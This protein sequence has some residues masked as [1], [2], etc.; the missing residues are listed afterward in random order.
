MISKNNY[1]KTGSQH[2]DIWVCFLLVAA[3]LA[4]YIQ[5]INHEFVNFDDPVYVTENRHVKGGLTLEG[6]IWAITTTYG[7]NWHPLTWLSHMLD[8]E[9]FGLDPGVHHLTNL[10]FHLANTLLLFF[11]FRRMTA[12]VWRS[13]FVAALFALHPLHV[14]S[15]AWIA[16]R[17]DVLS[18]FFWLLTMRCYIEYSDHPLKR[19]YLLVLLCFSLGLMAKPMLVSLPFVLLLLDYWPLGRIRFEYPDG[20]NAKSK[21]KTIALGLVAEKLPLFVLAEFSSVATFLAQKKGGAVASLELISLKT[22]I[23]NALIAYVNYM[24]KMLWPLKLAVFYPYSETLPWWEI[25]GAVLLLVFISWLSIKFIKQRPY[26]TVGWLW[27]LGTLVPVIGLVQVGSQALADRYTYIPL[28]G[29]FIIIAWGIPELVTRRTARKI[30]LAG[31]AT[32]TI[33]ALM[34]ATW[35]QVRYWK[36]SIALFEH[37]LKVTEK[38]HLAHNALGISLDSSRLEEA[39][40]H[41]LAALRIEPDYIEA[42]N[43]LGIALEIQGRPDEAIGHFQEALRAKPDDLKLHF[44]LGN[45]FLK[46][47]QMDQAVQHYTKALFIKTDFAGS[48]NNLGN[49]LLKQGRIDIAIEYYLDALRINPDSAGTHNNL[50][51][52]LLRKEDMAGAVN[53]FREALR[54]DPDDL[55]ARNNLKKVA[56]L[57]SALKK[58]R[59]Q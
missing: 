32:L 39:V 38:N 29:L 2:R 52:A 19:R 9:L 47:G 25:A 40:E 51:V 30:W 13:G 3:T 48:Y 17:K 44:N 37:T 28:I 57:K 4:V 21:P 53:H 43:N 7:S 33:L 15:V 46:K 45:I 55:D 42:H 22:R 26:F 31:L 12:D 16:E 36:N 1:K 6:V 5:V 56:G 24:L 14:E 11:V 50:G 23:F 49:I 41:Y 58:S 35:Q 54:I 10:L 8:H 34:V 27:Y 18:T 59:A 20:S